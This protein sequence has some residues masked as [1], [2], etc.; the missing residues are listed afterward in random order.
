[1]SVFEKLQSARV[2]RDA[3]AYADLMTEDCVFVRHQSGSEMG[4]AEIVEMLGKMMASGGNFGE[5]RL[6]YENDDIL[7]VQSIN[8]YPD[9]SRDSVLAVY[10][11]KGGKIAR[12][13]T[14]ATPLEK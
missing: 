4:K 7:V 1:M 2:N 5:T 3:Q 10:M 6:I 11:L 12:L 14:G 13:E 9:G 8:D